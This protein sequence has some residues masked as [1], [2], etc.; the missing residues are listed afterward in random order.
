MTR[1]TFNFILSFFFCRKLSDLVE[2]S[3]R[4]KVGFALCLG[5]NLRSLLTCNGVLSHIGV[6][7][8]ILVSKYHT[9]QTGTKQ[10]LI[11]L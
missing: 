5:L 10:L 2:F 6:I 3:E 8:R 4:R 11:H 9:I 7:D 1:F